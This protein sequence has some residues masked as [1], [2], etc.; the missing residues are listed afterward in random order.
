VVPMPSYSI[1]NLLLLWGFEC[2]VPLR[3]ASLGYEFV[4]VTNVVQWVMMVI[5]QRDFLRWLLFLGPVLS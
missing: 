3:F 4:H 2:L 5:F 1:P